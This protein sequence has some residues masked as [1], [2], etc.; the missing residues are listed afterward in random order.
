MNIRMNEHDIR[1]AEQSGFNRSKIQ[2]TNTKF[3]ESHSYSRSMTSDQS[4]HSSAGTLMVGSNFRVGKK[5][6]SGNFGELRLGN[7]YI[8]FRNY[9]Q[10]TLMLFFFHIIGNL[11]YARDSTVWLF[12]CH[13]VRSFKLS[14]SHSRLKIG[15]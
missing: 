11:N 6:G 14:R 8:Y 9:N 3:I 12:I 10:P 7:S 1:I 4:R 2:P 5:I 15:Q 13:A